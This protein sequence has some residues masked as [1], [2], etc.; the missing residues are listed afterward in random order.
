MGTLK[1]FKT[2]RNLSM[3]NQKARETAF[4]GMLFALAMTLSFL[5]SL[6]S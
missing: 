3:R 2:R 4:T 5:E 6:V 1:P